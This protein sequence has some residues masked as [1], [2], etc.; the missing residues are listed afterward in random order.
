MKKTVMLVSA[1]IFFAAFAFAQ[2][3]QKQ[4]KTTKSEPAKKECSPKQMKSCADKKDTKCCAHGTD[5]KKTTDEKAPE[6][7]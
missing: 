7:K 2:T 3:P 4:E 6:K 1:V 5:A